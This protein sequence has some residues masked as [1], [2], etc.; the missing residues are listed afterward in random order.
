MIRLSG[1]MTPRVIASR[2]SATFLPEKSRLRAAEAADSPAWR[3]PFS[4]FCCRAR[5]LPPA[6]AARLRAV[7]LRDEEPER[8]LDEERRLVELAFR[9]VD[10]ELRELLLER[11][12]PELDDLRDDD[13]PDDLLRD[14]PLPLLPLDSAIAI[15]LRSLVHAGVRAALYAHDGAN[16]CVIRQP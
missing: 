1:R 10:P 4:A 9:A 12:P 13:P 8:A 2:S 6:L 15:L 5:A 16:V 3:A 7:L 11:R 14:E